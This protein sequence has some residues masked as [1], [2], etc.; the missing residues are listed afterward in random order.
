[1]TTLPLV[2]SL[3]CE[4]STWTETGHASSLK[5]VN[6]SPRFIVKSL[7]RE[8]EQRTKDKNVIASSKTTFRNAFYRRISVTDGG[9]K[10]VIFLS[11]KS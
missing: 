10:V 4:I 9:E 8:R 11:E 6:T 3:T 7:E 2:S 1:M 5:A